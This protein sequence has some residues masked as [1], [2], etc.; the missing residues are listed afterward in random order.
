MLKVYLSL[1]NFPIL[2][3]KNNFICHTCALG[4]NHALP[5][6]KSHIEYHLPLQFVVADVWGLIIFFNYCLIAGDTNL[7]SDCCILF[8]INCYLI[9]NVTNY[10]LIIV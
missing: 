4:K 3:T 10:Y 1:V 5:F 2:A 6:S 8:Y 7:L 9:I